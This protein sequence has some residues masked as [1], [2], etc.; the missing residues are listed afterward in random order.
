[1]HRLPDVVYQPLSQVQQNPFSHVINSDIDLSRA[2]IKD[3]KNK[4]YVMANGFTYSKSFL[5]ECKQGVMNSI[6][7][8]VCAFLLGPPPK[9]LKGQP[10]VSKIQNDMKKYC[11]S[12][13][14]GE[15]YGSHELDKI[16]EYCYQRDIVGVRYNEIK[17]QYYPER[18]YDKNKKERNKWQ[19]TVMRLYRVVKACREEEK[20]HYSKK[21]RFMCRNFTETELARGGDAVDEPP[22]KEFELQTYRMGFWA[23]IPPKKYYER[24][25]Y[26]GHSATHSGTRITESTVQ[27][28][29]WIPNMEAYLR[30][31]MQNCTVCQLK[32]AKNK[33]SRRPASN[34]MYEE[35]PLDRIQADLIKLPETLKEEGTMYQYILTIIDH[36]SKKAWAKVLKNKR[37]ESV[38]V[39]IGKLCDKIYARRGQ[40][41]RILH[42]D[43]G[44][45]FRNQY[46]DA[47]AKEKSIK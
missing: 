15:I 12:K 38:C 4:Y 9:A 34:M 37:A 5:Q 41:P 46:M 29:Y 25:L 33:I 32:M 6:A 8:K 36:H 24:V 31:F 19:Q 43:N 3:R 17:R 40:Y 28:R 18:L 21:G 42:T 45:E 35:N 16:Y 2:C 14:D 13:C 7:D 22:V 10:T 30:A 26:E 20:S 47:M 39:I 23:E 44:S 27:N 11:L 1:M